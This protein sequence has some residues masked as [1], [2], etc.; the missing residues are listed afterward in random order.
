MTSIGIVTT[1]FEKGAGY[2]SKQFY[3]ILKNHFRVLIYA[4]GGER[5]ARGNPEWDF[6]GV[7]WAER[8]FGESM[9]GVD[10]EHFFKWINTN[11]IKLVIFNEQNDFRIL[12]ECKKRSLLI[13]AYIDYYKKGDIEKFKVYDGLIC[14]TKRHYSVFKD[15]PNA[16]YIPWGTDVTLFKQS[17]IKDKYKKVI[18]FHNAGFL[19]KNKRKGTVELLKAFRRIK[20]KDKRLII[21][22]QVSLAGLGARYFFYSIFSPRIKIIRKNI[23]GLFHLGDV[24]VYPT[25]HEGIGLT[26][27]EALASGTPVI[28]TNSPPM[29]EFIIDGYNGKLIKVLKYVPRSDN[30]YWDEAVIS[31]PDL[32]NKMEY[33]LN[34]REEINTYKINARDYA[35]KERDWNKNGIALV[36]Y[37]KSFLKSSK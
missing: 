32:Q 28:T 18:F 29:N 23:Y 13:I 12:Y 20:N 10:P 26:I 2:V 6:E 37:I 36:D 5:T 19:G 31:I 17:S 34:H 25:K 4:R 7:T 22:S 24:Y 16:V 33:F 21:H 1:W 30:H 9:T 11:N 35:I 8:R 14:N 15:F 27:C 3:N